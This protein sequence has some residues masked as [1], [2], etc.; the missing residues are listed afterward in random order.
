MTFSL[1]L[2]FL[3]K[4]LIKSTKYYQIR[5]QWVLINENQQNR[6]VTSADIDNRVFEKKI[7]MAA[8]INFFEIGQVRCRF[9]LIQTR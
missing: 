5:D 1:F 7:K 8:N 4:L 2:P 3:H 6:L 9:L